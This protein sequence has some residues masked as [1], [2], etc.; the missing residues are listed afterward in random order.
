MYRGKLCT[1]RCIN[2]EIFSVN[3]PVH[4]FLS[5][6]RG[7][8]HYWQVSIT[9][10]INSDSYHTCNLPRG[11]HKFRLLSLD[12]HN[13]ALVSSIKCSRSDITLRVG[14]TS[15]NVQERPYS[16]FLD[17]FNSRKSH[18]GITNSLIFFQ[19]RVF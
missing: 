14:F 4:Y 19:S 3:I 7:S 15:Y 6:F 10:S 8:F 18:Y 9:F 16:T 5:G 11:K 12:M 13:N 1:G 2:L 17:T